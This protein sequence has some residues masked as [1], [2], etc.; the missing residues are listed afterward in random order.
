MKF[1]LVPIC[2]IPIAYGFGLAHL[3]DGIV[4][5]TILIMAA[6]PPAFMSLIPPKLYGL[7][8]NLANSSWLVN[9]GMLV[10]VLPLLYVVIQLF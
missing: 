9:T 5:K 10:I 2:I 3:H 4:L 7:D 6:M 8:V 1:I